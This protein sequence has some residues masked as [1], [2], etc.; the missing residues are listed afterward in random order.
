MSGND[1][2]YAVSNTT[3]EDRRADIIF[4]HGLGGSSHDTW[5]HGREGAPGHFFWPEE[6]GNDL[7][8]CGIWTVGYP[9]G[10]TR[11]GKPGMIIE[12][13]AGNLSHK[14][15]NA[16][17]ESRP[18]I[19]VCHSMGGLVV[20]SLLADSQ[21]NADEARKR[22]ASMA[23][24]IVFCATPH[25]GSAFADAATVLGQFFLGTQAHVEEMRAN[26]EPLDLLHDRFIEW[27]RQTRTPIESYAENIGLFRTGLMGRSIPLG[28]VVPRASANTGIAG[29]TVK[30]IDVDHLTL[31]KPSHRQHDVYAGVLRFIRTILQ[32]SA[33][34]KRVGSVKL[35]PPVAPL[36]LYFSRRSSFPSVDFSIANEGSA[37]IQI[38]SVRSIIAG[39]TK[40]NHTGVDHLTGVR[41]A[42]QVDVMSN[43]E[44]AGLELLGNRVIL[45]Q[46]G[47]I[48]GFA[49]T[50]EIANAVALLDIDIDYVDVG[51]RRQKTWS[52]NDLVLTHAPVEQLGVQGSFELIDRER[53]LNILSGSEGF[54][55]WRGQPYGDCRAWRNALAR[56][57][58]C[59]LIGD[60]EN[61]W[62]V[63]RFLLKTHPEAGPIWASVAEAALRRS[64]P[65]MIVEELRSQV[66]APRLAGKLGISDDEAYAVTIASAL[67]Q[68]AS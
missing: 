8:D 56:G 26:E 66:A 15:A 48:E 7:G 52:P 11:L 29:F 25:R 51:A 9:A 10:F 53:G 23:R 41:V 35:A 12:K 20:K 6:L 24:G 38:T 43:K 13:R 27:Q 21:A 3:L 67:K 36:G 63:L 39:R 54:S 60:E 59:F 32:E 45:L 4:V 16:G 14:L 1:G 44:G 31:V 37:P 62:P 68:L 58:G 64:L 55:P 30:D 49:L 17:L 47:E 46:P 33:T 2:L 57:A 5:R 19:F 34:E 18:L 42:L 22:I 50:V 28:L 61:R 65:Q 40:D